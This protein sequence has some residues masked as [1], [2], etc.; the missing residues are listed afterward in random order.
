M[1]A[2]TTPPNI[3]LGAKAAVAVSFVR[4]CCFF[5]PERKEVYVHG[6]KNMFMLRKRGCTN[7]NFEAKQNWEFI[8]RN[9]SFEV[10]FAE[11]SFENLFS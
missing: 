10:K 2:A 1:T 8:V 5:V 9:S 6:G 7:F 3:W 11:I 4:V